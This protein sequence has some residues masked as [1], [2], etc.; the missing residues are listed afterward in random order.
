MII[1]PA[2][3]ITAFVLCF[4]STPLV[5]NFF[6][7]LGKLD[8]PDSHRKFHIAAVPRSGGIG[9]VLSYFAAFALMY[10]FLPAGSVVYI[11]HK[12]L[13]R[14]V[15]PAT[16]LMF[17]VGLADDLLDLRPRMKLAGQFVAVLVAVSMGVRLSLLH[18]PG[19]L[20]FTLSV[21]WLLTCT[22]AVNLI[23]GMDG[24]AAGVGLTATITT[25]LVALLSGNL[26]LAMATAP[27]A[28][29][30]FAFL[31]YNFSPAS[32][33]LG[34]SGS[35]TIGFL[36]GC[37]GLVW[38]THSG[39]LGMVGPLMTMALPLVDVSLAIGRRFLRRQP[40]FKGDRGHIHHR[41]LALGFTTRSAAVLLYSCCFVSA[42]LA[43]VQTFGRREMG[44]AI[45]LLFMVLVL[46]GV[47]SLGYVEF[48]AA[49]KT[50]SHRAI[51]KAFADE[52]YLE[53]L[54]HALTE[55]QT[56]DDCWM[57]LRRT[58]N[59]L[60]RAG[61]HL[62]LGSE[63]AIREAMLASD[64]ASCQLRVLL[65]ENTWLL[66]TGHTHLA[67]LS[68]ANLTHHI[69]AAVQQRLATLQTSTMTLNK[70]A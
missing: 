67:T 50:L 51:R 2:L 25:L 45:V 24:L 6:H 65:A 39:M 9:I 44:I 27:L 22:N 11:N 12:S 54:R 69:Q 26:G 68:L 35:L 56:P 62:Q 66:L 42:S 3:G 30:L 34:D 43:L 61:A 59:E 10:V 7:R 49:R 58:C 57:I 31:R 14:G 8:K 29:A 1:I 21:V 36:L 18:G 16:A 48:R 23:D 37:L 15:L 60:S 47:R 53:E 20:G 46:I 55:A 70:A 4:V 52:I 40:I 28:G 41:V 19:W 33:F 63:R 64:T 5:R 17:L 38:D 13:L 32:V